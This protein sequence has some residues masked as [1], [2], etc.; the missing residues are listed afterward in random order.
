MTTMKIDS[1]MPNRLSMNVS[2]GKQTQGATF[3]ERVAS[4]LNVAGS[5]IASGA[6]LVGGMIPGAGIVS[7]A[8]SS[9]GQLSNMPGGSASAASYAAS[10][11]TLS[12]GMGTTV[13]TGGGTVVNGGS[14]TGINFTSGATSNQTGMMNNEIS[15]MSAEN[16]KLLN[17]QIQMQHESQVFQSVSNVLKSKHDCIKNSIS[18]IR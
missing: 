1:S 6:S 11:V 5:A 12:G 10:G 13:G 16:A 3:G 14:S 15:S 2:I 7:A 17:T 18:N 4:G 8:V 9:V